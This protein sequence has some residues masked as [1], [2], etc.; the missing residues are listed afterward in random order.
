M[1]AMGN[2]V[3]GAIIAGPGK[4]LVVADLANIEGRL[5]AW[6]AGEVWKLDA[7]RAFDAKLGSP[8]LSMPPHFYLAEAQVHADAARA[9]MRDAELATAASRIAAD[10]LRKI[11]NGPP[12][13]DACAK[14]REFGRA[15]QVEAR[16][17]K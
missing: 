17:G 8:L 10:S 4:K 9:A 1:E 13:T 14:A 2:T 11:A 7:F 15:Y 3:R 6:I 16:G 5:Q 12:L